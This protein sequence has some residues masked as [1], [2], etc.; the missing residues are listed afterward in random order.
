MKTVW[1]LI[2]LA[3]CTAASGQGTSCT[4]AISLTLD[5]SCRSYAISSTTGTALHC[6]SGLYA[7]TGQ[8]TVFKFTTNSSASCVLV[9]ITTSGGQAAEVSMFDLCSGGGNLQSPQHDLIPSHVCFDD[10]TGYWAPCETEV[11]TANTTYYL[12][13][14]TPGTGTITMCAKHYTPP[15]NTCAG[16]TPIS[17]TPILDNN[18]C[19]RGSTEVYPD[20]LCANSLENT[21]F[22]SYTIDVT[23]ASIVT[24]SNIS[25][26]N[27][28]LGV[29]AGFQIGFFTGNCG[30][31]TWQ[32]CFADSNGTVNATTGSFPAGTRI[33]VA[34]DGMI[35]SNCSYTISAFNAIPLPA[36]LRYFSAW[37]KPN[38]NGLKWL[39][40]AETNSPHFD[41]E[42]SLDGLNFFKVAA[43]EGKNRN[44][45]E[46][47]Y[48]FDDPAISAN[49]YYR[50]KIV[51]TNGNFVYSNIARI[52][53]ED[54]PEES[55]TFQNFVSDKL[56]LKVSS[57]EGKTANIR[58]IDALGRERKIQHTN[59][60]KGESSCTIDVQS[61]NRGIY[62]LVF[63]DNNSQKQWSFIKL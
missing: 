6:T 59:F 23:G 34:I 20:A 45:T 49:Q 13:V 15:N 18:S 40:L 31:L 47:N 4:N 3:Y 60:N 2:L 54:I 33:T 22:Y 39:T 35:G 63:S 12:R 46:T 1:A 10:G 42:K 62:Y 41:I 51:G 61:L 37:K 44:N 50:L 29:N 9:H 8:L 43:V 16:A 26:D 36:S 7:G 38:S 30:A 57:I 32:S 58:I 11:L 53:R 21:A 17:S 19:N 55:I 14:W 27:S 25:C 28:D 52:K 5:D 48:A 24:I 56:V